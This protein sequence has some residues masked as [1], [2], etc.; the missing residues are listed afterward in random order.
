MRTRHLALLMAAGLA[1]FVVLKRVG[2]D[3]CV[4]PLD[5]G[6]TIDDDTDDTLA[7]QAAI[8][9]TPPRGTLC[10]PPGHLRASRNPRGWNRFAAV[11]THHK[12]LTVRCERG[13]SYL[14][15]VGDQGGVS[16]ILWSVDAGAEDV[17]FDGCTF[18]STGAWNTDEQTHI[19][20]TTG[21]CSQA[22]GTCTPIKNLAIRNFTCVHPRGTTRR[23][24]C[25]R[26]LGDTLA[27]VVDGV[28]IEDSVL[29]GA[30]SG[31]ELQRGLRNVTIRRTRFIGA[32]ADQHID[33]E[34]SGVS[35][36]LEVRDVVITENDF[37]CGAATQGDYDIS[38]TSADNVE[39]FA[40]RMCRGV[41]VVKSTRVAI[42]DEVIW[43]KARSNQGV[44]E[45]S[46]VC[47]GLRVSNNTL[48]RE[49]VTG[50][51]VRLVA[52]GTG[53]CDDAT[54]E[55]NAMVQ[56][57]PSFG[58]Y[59]ESSSRLRVLANTMSWLTPA[60]GVTAVYA[61]GTSAPVT[62]LEVDRNV[63]VGGALT[64]VSALLGS[65]FS[66]VAPRLGLNFA[67]V[68]ACTGSGCP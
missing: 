8:D 37:P 22:R 16:T 9:A 55:G 2:A 11:G 12:G 53:T 67:S 61:R 30:R 64:A 57:T 43:L 18:T 60:T 28:V 23:G 3:V 19:V 14:D 31:V 51:L 33:G 50:P 5:Y 21:V 44:I 1:A 66:V 42:H 54:V 36:G 38:L 10:M 32:T 39:I 46:N 41:A 40:N 48:V 34:A 4:S 49:G 24:D 35:P 47:G 15:L 56:M 52:H 68:G 7:L 59:S 20:A 17:T 29:D 6:A 26:L 63:V 58:V 45:V 65:P 62:G 27:T 13:L 25:I